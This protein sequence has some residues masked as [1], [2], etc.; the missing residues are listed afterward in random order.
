MCAVHSCVLYIHVCCVFMYALHSCVL[1]I[2]SLPSSP[3]LLC[4][5][6]RN[7]GE[8]LACSTICN[9]INALLNIVKTTYEVTGS[10]NTK[11]FLRCL[12]SKSTSDPAKWLHG[13]KEKVRSLTFERSMKAGTN[14]DQSASKCTL[15]DTPC[16]H[17]SMRCNN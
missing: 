5:G 7:A 6:V 1:C 16:L 11:L 3:Y 15:C 9:G 4:Q 2:C 14:M 10:D 8:S 12:E 17:A 13:L